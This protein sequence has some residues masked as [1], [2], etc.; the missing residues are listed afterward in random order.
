[1]TRVTLPW[2]S[3]SKTVRVRREVAI[4]PIF[5]TDRI[6]RNIPGDIGIEIPET[7]VIEADAEVAFLGVGQAVV[8]ACARAADGVAERLV[9]IGLRLGA[10][11]V[12]QGNG[13]AHCIVT[14]KLVV[15]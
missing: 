1:M 14:E 11:T 3:R 12:R 13:V 2:A 10:M 7:V 5:V 15:R 9:V 6:A 8:V 4:Q